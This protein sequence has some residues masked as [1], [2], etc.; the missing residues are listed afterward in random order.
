[1]T[2]SAMAA[3]NTEKFLFCGCGGLGLGLGGVGLG[4]GAVG[5]GLGGWGLGLGD[6]GCVHGTSGAYCLSMLYLGAVAGSWS[7]ACMA[8]P[9]AVHAGAHGMKGR[10][11]GDALA[12]P[13][14]RLSDRS[15]SSA[16]QVSGCYVMCLC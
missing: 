5:L 11:R 16:V 13:A 8:A 14:V 2:S 3:V 15:G 9:G 4:L 1:M 12:P 10:L 6:L 7:C